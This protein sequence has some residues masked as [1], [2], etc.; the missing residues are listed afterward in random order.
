M[1]RCVNVFLYQFF[2]QQN[3]IF[4]VVT[5]PCHEADQRVFTQSQFTFACGSAVSDDLTSF[6]SLTQIYDRF[7]VQAC[8]L[9]RSLIFDQFI[10][11]SLRVVVS[12]YDF[13]SRNSFY[14]TAYFRDGADTGVFCCF[15]FHTCTNNGR[16]CYQQ[17]YRLTLHVGT[18]QRTVRV[19]VFQEG[20]QCCCNGNH[21]FG[22][23]VHQV[24]LMSVYFDDFFSVTTG[25]FL[26][27]EVTFFIQ[28]FVGLRY[29][30]VFFFIS[31]YVDEFICNARFIAAV[32][33]FSIGSFD[34]AVFVD[35]CECGQC[36]DQ[37]DVRTFWC[38][39]RTHS[40]V[41]RMVNVSNFEARSFSGQ[42][43]GA[44]CRQSS[45]MC[46][47]GQRVV[48]VHEL[49]QLRGTKEFL[50]RCCYRTNVD[51][52]LRCYNRQILC[53]HSFTYHSFHSGQTD[54]E[55]VLQQFANGTDTSVALVVD[56]VYVA[57]AVIQ[58]HHIVDGSKDVFQCD[59]FGQQFVDVFFDRCFQFFRC[60]VFFQQF[61]Q[62][63]IVNSFLDAQFFCIQTKFFNI[64]IDLNNLVCQNFY[65]SVFYCDINV[66]NTCIL[67][68][69]AQFH[70]QDSAFFSH[71]F[72][73]H[74][75]NYVFSQ[76]CTFYTVSQC[77]FFVEFITAYFCQVVSLRIEEHTIQ[78][79]SGAFYCRGFAGTQLL[80][81]FD[82]TFFIRFCCVFFQS[83]QDLG[84]F[85]EQFNDLSI[86][87]NAHCS[88]QNGYGNF[89]CSVNSYIEYIVGVCFIFQP[90]ASVGDHCGRKQLFTNF[91]EIRCIVDAGGTNQL[92]NDNTFRT[93][94]DECTCFCH[95]REI[96]HEDFLFFQFVQFSVV[97]SC[98]HLQGCGISR[99]SFLAFFNRVFGLGIQRKVDKF[100]D[101]VAA[102]V[103][104]GRNILE[105]FFQAFVQEPLVAVLLHFNQVGHFQNFIDL[106]IAHSGCV[107][108]LEC[109]NSV[110]V[111]LV[112]SRNLNCTDNKTCRCY[113]G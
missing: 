73:C 14:D 23:N 7:L 72:A 87:T 106:G 17:R 49:R 63:R 75:V 55:L 105:Y 11:I 111:H 38:F 24:D 66:A 20:D 90:C 56:I 109:T 79:G 42:T 39:D 57:V 31:C 21:L 64:R 97:K 92:R 93:I 10:Y 98:L 33:Y 4:V 95:Q 54:T 12:Y 74:R 69:I 13:I 32:I 5:F 110:F 81:N 78:Q 22:G 46:Q 70:C 113:S 103:C 108:K 80:I 47:F 16:V 37:T 100:Q 15:V 59:V 62:H 30:V 107:A 50:D 77:Q 51:Q 68:L 34:K 29:V 44:Q 52:S 26:M 25:Y 85:A 58:M 84:F 8:A 94:D 43:A 76:H 67:D 102:E 6:Y 27:N 99:V 36:I 86:G 91:I 83:C 18:H 60:C 104:N 101:Q 45:L 19:I 1:N 112:T 88:D 2:A 71:Y 3:G 28:R 40:A 48:L 96:T 82:Q 65:F 41:V 35:S 61:C 89:S 53:C 9:V